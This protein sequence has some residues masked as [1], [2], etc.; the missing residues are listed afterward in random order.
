[1]SVLG[2]DRYEWQARLVPGLL[3]LFPIAVTITA[4][5]FRHGPIG[6]V[7]SSLV[8]LAGGSL[9]LA[10]VVRR[11]GTAE[12]RRLW[13]EWGGAPATIALRLRQ[14]TTNTGLRD[15]WRAAVEKV[16]GIQLAS[17]RSESANPER[18]DQSINAAVARVRELTRSSR[19]YLLQAENRSYGYRR[20]LFGVRVVGRLVAI[21]GMLCILGFSLW[22]LTVGHNADLQAACVLGFIIDTLFALG[23]WLLPS[24]SQVREAGEK[25]AHQLFE[26][27]VTLADDSATSPSTA[28][29]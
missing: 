8:S 22:P 25:Y 3:S 11:L 1:V 6:S 18:A 2:L 4:L 10:D 26:A 12:Q 17:L 9:V 19:F 21:L 13:T 23:W 14:S 29:G 15:S 5:G 7:I 16:S 24:S 27:A 20:N 28:Q